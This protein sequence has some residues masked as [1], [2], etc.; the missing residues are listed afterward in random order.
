MCVC[1]VRCMLFSF[2][3]LLQECIPRINREVPVIASDGVSVIMMDGFLDVVN[4]VDY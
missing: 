4:E 2:C 3:T 1:V